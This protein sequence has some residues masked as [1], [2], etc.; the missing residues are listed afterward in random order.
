MRAPE[1]WLQNVT[2]AETL[3]WP[4][5]LTVKQFKMSRTVMTA[6][7]E[8]A[9]GGVLMNVATGKTKEMTR[10]AY[11]NEGQEMR[12]AVTGHCEGDDI[13]KMMDRMEAW[14]MNMKAKKKTHMYHYAIGDGDLTEGMGGVAVGK[15]GNLLQD[16]RK[17]GWVRRAPG[18]TDPWTYYCVEGCFFSLHPEDQDLLSFNINLSGGCKVWLCVLPQYRSLVEAMVKQVY[19]STCADV[20]RHKMLFFPRAFFDSIGARYVLVGQTR[21]LIMVTL[22]HC[23]HQGF[24]VSPSVNVAVNMAS[25]KWIRHGLAATRASDQQLDL[26]T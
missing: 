3:R 22:P 21:G 26:C 6:R 11:E 16:A 10:E 20:L 12:A 17:G 19:P 5:T 1:K 14:L 7:E 9:T 24:N 25:I 23:L 8:R 2:T 18:V 15:I 4:E 13:G